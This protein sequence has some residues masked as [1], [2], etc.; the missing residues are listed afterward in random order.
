MVDYYVGHGL[1]AHGFVS[2]LYM[3]DWMVFIAG[4]MDPIRGAVEDLLAFGDLLSNL[5]DSLPDDSIPSR[6]SW[7]LGL[8]NNDCCVY[9]HPRARVFIG[10]VVLLS[11]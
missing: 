8:L 3:V 4:S 1:L 2:Y 6:K 9:C 11:T 7:D 5:Q 10:T